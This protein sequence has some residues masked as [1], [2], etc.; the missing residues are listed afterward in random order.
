MAPMYL[1]C[2]PLAVLLIRTIFIDKAAEYSRNS[3]IK[4]SEQLIKDIETYYQKNGHYPT[5]MLSLW[6]DYKTSVVGIKQYHYEPNGKSYNLY[7]QQ[8]PSNVATQEIIMYNKLDEHQMTSHDQD[9]LLLS[10]NDLNQQRG[11][12]AVQNLPNP[13]WKQFLFD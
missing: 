8:V 5:S 13:H 10:I 2:I 1:I 4:N 11:Y 3:A 7:F 12:F 6:K 9:L